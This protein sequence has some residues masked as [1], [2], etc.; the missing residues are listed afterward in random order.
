M[1]FI[2]SPLDNED[3]KFLFINKVDDSLIPKKFIPAIEKGFYQAMSNGPIAGYPLDNLKVE[4][5]GGSY[6]EEDSD[7]LSYEIV[8]RQAFR[9]ATLKAK[10]I[11]LEPVMDI[12]IVTP[13]EYL[14][15]IVSDLNKRR[16]KINGTT[17]RT[18][19]Q[20]ISASAPLSEMFGYVTILRTLSSGRASSTME[21]SHYGEV[22][23][24]ISEG[25]IARLTGKIFV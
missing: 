9:N 12:E 6:S 3:D 10:P 17:E 2:I 22:D 20:V 16:T 5:T 1:F 11:L 25:I 18:N 21:F 24:K 15:D 8:A 19:V 4:L 13:G 14:G 23:T 7:E